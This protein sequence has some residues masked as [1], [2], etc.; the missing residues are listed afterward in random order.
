MIKE[1]YDA[2]M[3]RIQRAAIDCGRPANTVGLVAVKDQH[4]MAFQV[5]AQRGVDVQTEA[6]AVPSA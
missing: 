1:R 4:G 2:I 3:E 5:Q 6:V